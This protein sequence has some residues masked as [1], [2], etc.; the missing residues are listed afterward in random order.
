MTRLRYV[1]EENNNPKVPTQQPGK[2]GFR[3]VLWFNGPTRRTFIN[4]TPEVPA[5]ICEKRNNCVWNH[6][7]AKT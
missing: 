7:D 2:K 3:E 1:P 4:I 6:I 5:C